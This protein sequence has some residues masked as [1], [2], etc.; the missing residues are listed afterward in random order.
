MASI[1]AK[2]SVT[3]LASMGPLCLWVCS[4]LSLSVLEVH[5]QALVFLMVLVV[6]MVLVFLVVLGGSWWSHS[7]RT[8]VA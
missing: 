4:S 7:C 6:L 1:L 5:P 3:V 2:L 8:L